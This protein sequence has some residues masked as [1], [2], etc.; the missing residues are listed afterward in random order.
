MPVAGNALLLSKLWNKPRAN[1]WD[2]EDTDRFSY[3][4]LKELWL[5][6]LLEWVRKDKHDEIADVIVQQQQVLVAQSPQLRGAEGCVSA[7]I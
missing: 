1:L 5:G 6:S 7:P 3:A 2:A 4:Y